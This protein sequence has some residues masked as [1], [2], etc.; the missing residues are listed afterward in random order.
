MYFAMYPG[1]CA[2]VQRTATFQIYYCENPQCDAL[3]GAR[4]QIEAVS[5]DLRKF[6]NWV[7]TFTRPTGT[8]G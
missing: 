6:S 4:N 8:E 1:F 5:S 3:G 2:Q 7:D